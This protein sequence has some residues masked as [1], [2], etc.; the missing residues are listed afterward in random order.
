VNDSA[1]APREG[2]PVRSVT[3]AA[4]LFLLLLLGTA[5]ARSWRDLE[6]SRGREAE[7]AV[8]IEETSARIDALERRIRRLRHDPLLVERLAR[9]ELGLAREG[10]VVFVVP[11]ASAPPPPAIPDP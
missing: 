5:G 11:E 6:R 8:K 1:A 4:V 2:R 9:E 3:V 7:L 10:D